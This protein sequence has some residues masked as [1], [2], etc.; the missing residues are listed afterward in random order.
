MRAFFVTFSHYRMSRR[1]GLDDDFSNTRPRAPLQP[2]VY[3]MSSQSSQDDRLERLQDD[4][5]DCFNN[6][7]HGQYVW[8]G[9]ISQGG[10]GSVYRFRQG[11]RRIAVKIVPDAFFDDGGG[12]NGSGGENGGNDGNGDDDNSGGEDDSSDEDPD[13]FDQL[14]VLDMEAFFLQYRGTFRHMTRWIYMEYA[15]NG[16]LQDFID[17]HL[18]LYQRPFPNRLMWRFFMCLVRS[19]LEMAYYD[20]GV[21]LSAT[22]LGTLPSMAPGPFAHLDMKGENIVIGDLLPELQNPEHVIS[23]IL[24]LID[25]G[26][27]EDV[28]D[29]EAR[30][31]RIGAQFAPTGSEL[32]IFDI[33]TV[34]LYILLH[35]AEGD[36]RVPPATEI[37]VGAMTYLSFGTVLSGRRQELVSSGVDEPLIDLICRCLAQDPKD[38]PG[39]IELAALVH[40]RVINRGPGDTPGESDNAIRQ[41]LR[42]VLLNANTGEAPVP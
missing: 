23:P 20:R 26:G 12:G 39:L 2:P 5:R 14:V 18:A 30:R 36:Y 27:S 15:E 24:K 42:D 32:N 17:R 25:F 10:N 7:P 21:D 3:A 34:M 19:S 4:L 16:M 37:T 8:E 29:P 31:Q 11:Q 35:E 1:D 33:A 6:D 40:E 9:F 28:V 41:L 38:R 22:S 13:W